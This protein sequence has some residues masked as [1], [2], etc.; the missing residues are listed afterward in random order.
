MRKASIV[1]GSIVGLMLASLAGPARAQQA[2]S[3]DLPPPP[4]PRER[5][6][7]LGAAVLPSAVGTFVAAPGGT[8]VETDA[9]FAVGV[10]LSVMY[11]VVAGLTVGFAPQV[12]YNVKPKEDGGDAATEY[13]VMARAAYTFR[14]G[15]GIGLYVEALPGYSL[16]KPPSGDTAKGLVLAAGGGAVMDLTPRVFTTFGVGYHVGFQTRAE[17]MMESDVRTRYVRISLGGGVRF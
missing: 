6:L 14:L 15:E 17:G 16:I 12:I 9:A 1:A 8:R 13:D 3:A 2:V 4:P 7:E 11:R 5:R 10:G